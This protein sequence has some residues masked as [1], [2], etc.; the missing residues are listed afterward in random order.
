MV[1]KHTGFKVSDHGFQFV[2]RFEFPTLFDHYLNINL[3]IPIKIGDVV[4]GLCGGMCFAATDYFLLDKK[5][6]TYRD[7][8]DIRLKL[9]IYLWNRQL[10]SLKLSSLRKL[11]QWM[12]RDDASLARTIKRWEIPKI[13]SEIDQRRPAVL[14]LVRVKGISDPTKNHQVLAIGYEHDVSTE[15]MNIQIYDPNYPK[16]EHSLT[17]D[18]SSTSQGLNLQ[19]T[20]DGSQRG[21][22]MLEYKKETPP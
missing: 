3:P 2:N 10:D 11:F 18:L 22:F 17:M 7:V 19:H 4:Y 8:D 1:A 20:K 14:A 5:I 13:R 21:F 6:P 9:F 15:E 12:L 16:K